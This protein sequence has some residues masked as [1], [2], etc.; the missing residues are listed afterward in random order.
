MIPFRKCTDRVR[1]NYL[2]EGKFRLDPSK[3][4]YTM[5]AM[6]PWNKLLRK[7][8]EV[9][10]FTARLDGTSGNLI[11]WEVSLSIA[12]VVRTGWSLMSFQTQTFL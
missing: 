2:E 8:V 7:V 10:V 3:Q 9:G 12:W 4:F 5:R 1:G 6:R 11:Q